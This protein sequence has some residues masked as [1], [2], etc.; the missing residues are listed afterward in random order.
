MPR[1]IKKYI[2]SCDLCQRNKTSTQKPFG[3]LNPIEPP[4]NKFQCYSMDFISPLP[5]TKNKDNA[6]LVIVDTLTKAVA[7][8]PIKTTDGAPIIA[9]IFFHKIIHRFGMPH[10]I[11]SDR[12]THFTGTFWRCLLELTN[13]KL[14]LSTA[15]HPQTDGQTEHTNRTL[16]QIL[17]NSVNYWHNNWDDYLS[18]AEFVIN[19]SPNDSTGFT[20][21]ELMYGLN[22]SMPINMLDNHSKVPAPEDF[23]KTMSEAITTAQNNIIKAQIQQ[24]KHAD[25]HR[26]DHQFKIG[27]LVLLSNRNIPSDRSAKLNPKFEGPFRITTKFGDNSF[28]LDLPDKTR[29][30]ATFHASLLK[31]YQP[32]DLE[33]FPN[34]VQEP[35]DLVLIDEAQ[36]FQVDRIL[37][38]R[39]HYRKKQYLIKWTGYPE[40]EATWE[41]TRNL[42]NAQD[43]IKN[44]EDLQSRSLMSI[45]SSTLDSPREQHYKEGMGMNEIF[46]K[47]IHTASATLE[48][49][50]TPTAYLPITIT[51]ATFWCQQHGSSHK[52]FIPDQHL[53]RGKHAAFCPCTHCHTV[54]KVIC[55]MTKAKKTT[56]FKCHRKGHLCKNCP[57]KGKNIQPRRMP[58]TKIRLTRP[59]KQELE[60]DWQQS[61]PDMIHPLEKAPSPPQSDSPHSEDLE[62]LTHEL[63]DDIKP[64]AFEFIPRILIPQVKTNP[65]AQV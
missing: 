13:T 17:R 37:G 21:F 62:N 53:P 40:Y 3:L 56:C 58:R 28:K 12:D 48:M 38:T 36:E 20:P 27:D 11:I 24:K 5:V 46:L 7:L 45:T 25:K 6:I 34:R 32:N 51:Q 47:N 54:N 43:A 23:I 26:R 55:E 63:W 30:H 15:Y 57:L 16:E 65:E 4:L 52:V 39:K 60:E 50:S 2:Q 19:S 1:D 41:D 44:F 9:K 10:K 61:R 22:P 64:S 49:A 18:A 42:T 33:L 35:P 31:P 29:I 59:N 14:A 8:T